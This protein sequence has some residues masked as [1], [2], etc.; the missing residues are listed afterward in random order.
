M[1]PNQKSKQS[2]VTNLYLYKHGVNLKLTNL[3]QIMGHCLGAAPTTT[4]Y[5]WASSMTQQRVCRYTSK[6]PYRA[7]ISEYRHGIGP[8]CAC[9][10]W[11]PYSFMIKR[12]SHRQSIELDFTC[13]SMPSNFFMSFERIE[14]WLTMRQ[15]FFSFLLL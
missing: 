1:P 13:P 14:K 8:D 10:F 4:T 15:V 7:R 12:S 2:R 5:Y 9:I 11:L 3:C 6:F